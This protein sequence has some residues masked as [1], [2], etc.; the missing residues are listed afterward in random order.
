MRERRRDPKTV[1][2][3]NPREQSNAFSALR[4]AYGW[5]S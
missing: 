1:Q 5:H 4:G 3:D 2:T